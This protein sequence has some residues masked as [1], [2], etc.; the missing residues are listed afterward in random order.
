MMIVAAV[1]DERDRQLVARQVDAPRPTAQEPNAPPSS[2]ISISSPAERRPRVGL[3][4]LKL[5]D[6]AG[7]VPDPGD[8]L[9]RRRRRNEDHVVAGFG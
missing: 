3:D 5:V 1:G 9:D 4:D 7:H 6:V 2:S 8:A